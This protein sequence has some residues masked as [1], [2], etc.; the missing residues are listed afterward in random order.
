M[1]ERVQV[2]VKDGIADVRLC[3]PEKRNALDQPMFH[4]LIKAGREL[5][6]DP[7]VRVAVLHGEGPAFCGGLDFMSFAEMLSGNLSADSDQ[8]KQAVEEKT[9]GGASWFQLP[10]WIWY[11]APFPVTERWCPS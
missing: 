7:S 8:V 1:N 3:R 5:S 6:A 2:E 11:E 10:A 4:G 9:E